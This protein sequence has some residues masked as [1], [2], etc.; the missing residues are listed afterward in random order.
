[1]DIRIIDIKENDEKLKIMRAL[2][3]VFSERDRERHTELY[4]EKICKYACFI[5]ALDGNQCVGFSAFYANDDITKT[6]YITLIAVSLSFQK[7][8]IGKKLIDATIQKANI[9]GM[10]KIRLEVDKE[11]IK[12]IQLYNKNGFSVFDETDRS[13]YMDKNINSRF[14]SH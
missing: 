8:G 10:E 13:F 6:A 12:A 1:M 4:F 14:E 7:M 11:N 5:E 2:E 3:N 9:C